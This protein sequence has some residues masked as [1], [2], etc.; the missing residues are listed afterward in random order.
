VALAGLCVGGL[1]TF[2]FASEHRMHLWSSGDVQVAHDVR[3][4]TPQD[5]VILTS[6][7][8]GQPV[9]GL[10]GRQVVMGF[11]GWLSTRGFDWARY[12]NDVTAMLA[13]D[14]PRMRRLGVDYVVLGPWESALAEEKRFK[15]GR[16]FEDPRHFDVVFDETYEGR[17]WRLLRRRS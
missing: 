17:E 3:M 1:L 5:A 13:G 14:V 12:E 10:S 4:A 15:I 16:V 6:N 8:H 11:T 7:G 9:N 2:V